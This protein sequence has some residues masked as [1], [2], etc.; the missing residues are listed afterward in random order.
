MSAPNPINPGIAANDY[1]VTGK[2]RAIKHCHELSDLAERA[3]LAQIEA[4]NAQCRWLADESDR[5]ARIQACVQTDRLLAAAARNWVSES[6]PVKVK[7]KHHWITQTVEAA[8]QEFGGYWALALAGL[9]VYM[10]TG[11]A[12]SGWWFVVIA[13]WLGG[14]L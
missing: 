4:F 13:K 10:G 14:Y 6:A 1:P 7:P 8:Q 11:I 5:M 2:E 3:K 9:A 12:V